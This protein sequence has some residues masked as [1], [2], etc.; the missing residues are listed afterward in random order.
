[1]SQLPPGGVLVR[2]QPVCGVPGPHHVP[3]GGHFTQGVHV[4]SGVLC[5]AGR[6]GGCLSKEPLL[7]ARDDPA[8]PLPAHTRCGGGPARVLPACPRP[9]TVE[10]GRGCLMGGMLLRWR[11]VLLPVPAL[12]VSP[13]PSSSQMGQ[14]NRYIPGTDKNFISRLTLGP[15]RLFSPARFRLLTLGPT[16]LFSPARF[17]LLALGLARLVCTTAQCLTL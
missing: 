13:T 8:Q 2:A 15:T 4:H 14:D 12:V 16:R 17:R 3:V 10:L 7:C 11:G 9:H 6:G 5:P 1:V